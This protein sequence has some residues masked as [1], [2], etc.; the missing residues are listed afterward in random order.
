MSGGKR[1]SDRVDRAA[2]ARKLAD[3]GL[4]QA[5]IA[6][7]LYLSLDQV[8]KLLRGYKPVRDRVNVAPV[9]YYRGANW[10]AGL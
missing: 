1:K 7:T 5:E 10:Q 3:A 4:T 2:R 8:N 9:P 6:E